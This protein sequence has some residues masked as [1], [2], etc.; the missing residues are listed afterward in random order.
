MAPFDHSKKTWENLRSSPSNHSSWKLNVEAAAKMH[1][2]WR[3]IQGRMIEPEFLDPDNPTKAKMAEHDEWE[4]TRDEAAGMLWLCIEPDQQEHVKAFRNDPEWIWDAL[5]A[6]HAA[7]T[8]APRFATL[9]NLLGI[10][11]EDDEP[12]MKFLARIT[13]IGGQWRELLP[14]TLS[15]NQLCEELQCIAAIRGISASHETVAT[16]LLQN[17]TTNL[18]LDAVRTSFYT[19]DNRPVINGGVTTTASAMRASS[20]S[21]L[22][23]PYT[24]A[25]ARPSAQ[26]LQCVFCDREGHV[27]AD[28]YGRQNAMKKLK[29][30]TNLKKVTTANAATTDQTTTHL[31]YHRHHPVAPPRGSSWVPSDVALRVPKRYPPAGPAGGIWSIWGRGHMRGSAGGGER[32]YIHVTC[33]HL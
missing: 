27:E 11:R 31:S 13:N 29:A 30:R 6:L 16:H 33:L 8:A 21:S 7:Q 3:A 17:N 9:I 14:P 22:S 10:V 2:L 15:L 18:T 25:L 23:T 32:K 19:E 1:H 5:E 24:P 28:C 4:D 20:I 12:L 26:L